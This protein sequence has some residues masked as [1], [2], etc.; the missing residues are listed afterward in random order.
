MEKEKKV[1]KKN[2]NKIKYSTGETEEIRHLII[3]ILVVIIAVCGLY[4]ATRAFVTKDLFTKKEAETEEVTP[5]EISY[6]NIIVG[7]ILNR[8][9]DEYYV[10]VYNT[11]EGDYSYDMQIL[12]SEYSVLDKHL[13][14]YTVDLAN[15]LNADYYDSENASTEA[16]D[17]KDIKFGDITLIKVKNGKMVKYIVDYSKMEKE[18]GVN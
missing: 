8:P 6:E 16:T 14:I 3:V 5:G 4:L 17:L 1:V 9:Y 18:L 2:K 11:E 15:K 12:T 7:Q 13:H 10:V